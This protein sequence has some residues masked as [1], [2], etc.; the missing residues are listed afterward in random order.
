MAIELREYQAEALA[1]L[2]ADWQAGYHRIGVSAATGTGKTVIMSHLAHRHVAAGVRVLI[3]VHRD[4]LVRQTVD[5]LVRVN[6]S[7]SI[8]VV[9]ATR[10]EASSQIVVASVATACRPRRMAQLGKF[11]LIICDEAHRSA[12]QQWVDVLTGLGSL[13]EDTTVRTAGF[14]ATW[15]RADGKGLDQ[16]WQKISFELSLTW[17]IEQG[18]LVRPIG[19]YI[20]T[21]VRLDGLKKTAGDYNAG[22]L[23]AK[24]SRESVREAIVA[25]Y[26]QYAADRSG[27]VFAPTVATAE[28][29]LPAFRSA[30][31]SAEGLYGI[32]G[33]EESL[34]IHKRHRAGD[35][36]LLISCTKLSEGWD[37]P[38]CSAA[39]IARPTTHQGLFV[40]QVGRVLRP[41][42]GKNDAVILDPTGVLYKHKLD[43]VI[44]LTSS[45]KMES[46]EDDDELEPR[47]PTEQEAGWV[48]AQ[49]SGFERVEML[50]LPYLLTEGGI[51]FSHESTSAVRF[52]ISPERNAHPWYSVGSMPLGPGRGRWLATQLTHEQAMSMLPDRHQTPS[53]LLRNRKSN[54]RQRD[55]ARAYGLRP[56]TNA[57]AGD[58]FDQVQTVLA[59]RALDAVQSWT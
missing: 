13:D 32:T 19:Q 39:V 9:Q 20:R 46:D 38:W 16:I 28:F 17:A 37:A 12:A 33:K 21:E 48:D 15:T 41:F 29:F 56:R 11:G 25:G 7:V 55:S 26:L 35:T 22:D 51:P 49:V 42:K 50:S 5:K 24:L 34:Q 52:V 54:G 8:G 53:P 43:G 3:L 30:G 59:S 45:E 36:Q 40:Q 27:V 4:E 23:G 10:N 57:L 1:A 6:N 14:S 58:L 47:E 2:E 31:I 44:D 18:F